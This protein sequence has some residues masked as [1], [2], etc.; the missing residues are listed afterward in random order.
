MSFNRI[1]FRQRRTVVPL[2]RILA[3][4]AHRS[5]SEQYQRNGGR[6]GIGAAQDDSSGMSVQAF[7]AAGTEVASRH[8]DRNGTFTF[9]L[10]P[11]S[12]VYRLIVWDER[13]CWWGREIPDLP[14]DSPNTT[15]P[16]ILLRPQTS[17]LSKAEESEESAVIVWLKKHNPLSRQP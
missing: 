9:G 16:A 1:A 10:D 17:A 5:K 2:R 13:N 14:N 6:T 8:T 7:E 3:N 11:K 4:Y 15:L 12:R